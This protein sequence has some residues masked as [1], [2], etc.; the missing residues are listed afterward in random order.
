MARYRRGTTAVR[1]DLRVPPAKRSAVI[2]TCD[3]P[4]EL[5]EMLT[6]LALQTVLIHQFIVVNNSR[7]ERPTREVLERCSQSLSL[8]IIYL[9]GEPVFGTATGRNA[10]LAECTGEIVFL[11]DDDLVFSDRRYVEKVCQVFDQDD[12]HA[13]GAVVTLAEP[14]L[15]ASFPV[16]LQ[17]LGRRCAKAFFGMDGLRPGTVTRS[18]FQVSMPSGRIMDVDWLQSGVSAIRGEVA[19][20]M[21]FD[22][23][24]ERRPLALSEDVEFGL[25][26]RRRWRIVCLG[27]TFAVN[28][29]L[30]RGGTANQWLDDEQRYELI[31]RNYDRINRR[32]RPGHINRLAYWR[33][34][35][36]ICLERVVARLLRRPGAVAAWRGYT[37]GLRGVVRRRDAA[38]L[39]ER[40]VRRAVLGAGTRS[41]R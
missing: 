11:F 37:R 21:R 13:I 6:G 18:G 1:K 16:T 4:D 14:P 41:T 35:S 32:H 5:A 19:H 38:V 36:G 2:L 15:R 31:V 20:G 10:A 33:A 9:R 8:S 24:L 3:R 34:M 7:L 26:I 12:E 22:T 29:H 28:G 23:G 27:T 39:P 40:T 25:Q 17:R 30:K